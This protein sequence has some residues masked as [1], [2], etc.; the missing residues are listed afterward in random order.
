MRRHIL[1][2]DEGTT[3][4]TVRL[5]DRRARVVREAAEDFRQIYPRPGWV[6]HDPQEIWRVT[7]RLVRRVVSNPRDIEAVGV[8]NQ[9]ETT[10]VWDRKTGKPV[11]NAIVWQ[12]RRTAPM[13]RRL[14][15]DGAEPLVRR[16]TG[17]VIDAYFSATKI[18]WIL[19][20]V[21]RRPNLAFGTIDTWLLWK[22]TGGRVHATDHTNAS[23]TML[24]D[25]DRRRWDGDLLRLVRVPPSLL[26]EA[27]D[28]AGDF[29]RT[30]RHVFGA[31]VPVA[32]IAGDQQAALFG[33]GCF[34]RGTMKNTYGT[35]CFLVANTGP[36]RINSKR[37]LITT[38][39]CGARGEPVY[40]LEGS[41]FIAGAVVQ[42]LRDSLGIIADASQSEALARSIESTG[43]VYFVPA[44]VGL[45][46]PYWDMQARGTVVGLTRGAGRAEIARAS[47]EAIAYQTRDVVEA[48]QADAGLK[49]RELRVDGG[50]V[51]NDFLMQFQA[52]ILGARIVR[53]K[54]IES[55]SLGAALLAGLGT[56]F[57][58]EPPLSPVDRS[59][60][61]KMAPRQREALYAGWQQ[62]VRR[63]R[64]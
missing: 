14:R 11:H 34:T 60:T 21:G 35:G 27:R 9:R 47:L 44:F 38:L 23:R 19:D 26:P 20:R 17:L 31:E 42:W 39:A 46:A 49:I 52:D 61:P 4:V 51:V 36:H 54:N 53:P 55:T 56:G 15:E 62:A 7:H 59:W 22:L 18:R 3:G 16:K 13:C 1:A 12:C 40:A 8:T 37:G 43:G 28:S 45:G 63:A 30:D 24:Y 58:T 64:G 2:I 48:M 33:Q 6:E 25:I 10:V 29:G 57:W 5:F 32:G 41:V 50:A